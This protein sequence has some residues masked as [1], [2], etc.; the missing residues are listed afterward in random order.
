MG[1]NEAYLE[2]HQRNIAVGDRH[3]MVVYGDR[4]VRYPITPPER[5]FSVRR[6]TMVINGEMIRR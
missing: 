4:F 3:I 1:L 2:G 6:K 5:G